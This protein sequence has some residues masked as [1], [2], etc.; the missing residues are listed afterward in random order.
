VV[1]AHLN[2]ALF[3]CV[4]AWCTNVATS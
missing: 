4:R 3:Q 2:F 1:H